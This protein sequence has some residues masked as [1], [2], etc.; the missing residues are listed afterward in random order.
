MGH[1]IEDC[2]PNVDELAVD[3]FGYQSNLQLANSIM[4]MSSLYELEMHILSHRYPHG[5]KWE[6][7]VPKESGLERCML[8]GP[9]SPCYPELTLQVDKRNIHLDCHRLERVVFLEALKLEAT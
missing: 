3:L 5:C 2:L 9:G 1:N 7:T 4:A 8:C 6:L